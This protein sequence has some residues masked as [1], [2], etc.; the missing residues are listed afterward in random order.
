MEGGNLRGLPF[1][2]RFEQL[3]VRWSIAPHL[4]EQAMADPDVAR[5]VRRGL[6]FMHLEAVEVKKR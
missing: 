4:L 6:I 1:W 2:Y 5:W 3:A